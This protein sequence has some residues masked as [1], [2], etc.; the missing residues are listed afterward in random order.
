VE[1]SADEIRQQLDRIA[2]SPMFANADRMTAFLRFVVDR[3]LA[4]QADQ[5]KEY[6]VGVAVFGRSDDYDP[7][8]DSIVRVEARRL[9]TKLDE[10]YAS[11]GRNDAVIVRI[12]RG[13]YVP[14][15]ERR[16]TAAA[17]TTVPSSTVETSRPKSSWRPAAIALVL[18]LLAVLPLGF[19]LWRADF[20]SSVGS[21]TPIVTIGVLPFSEYSTDPADDLLAAQL[22][23]GVTSALA[24]NRSLGVASH[25]SA[26][27]FAGAR[28]PL[29]EIAQALKVE[30]ILEGSVTRTAD[31]LRIEGRLVDVALNRKVWVE[32][33]VGSVAQLEDLERRMAIAVGQ[34]AERARRR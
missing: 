6:V 22:T 34:A 18:V 9:R 27:Q 23:D 10:Y 26:Q 16:D 20:G 31:R 28:R 32:E 8:L 19:L 33:F 15:F 13:S 29:P 4:G 1:P 25:T 3:A 12:P 11:E 24:R 14:V 5:L 21:A 7:R 2:A 17:D 30:M